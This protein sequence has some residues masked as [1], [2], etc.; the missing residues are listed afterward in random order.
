MNK[1]LYRIIFNKKRGQLMA[2]AEISSSQGKGQ[3]GESGANYLLSDSKLAVWMNAVALAVTCAVGAIGFI[4]SL[5]PRPAFA[6]VVANRNAPANQQA[7]VLQTANGLPQ[8]N[9]QTPNSAGVSVNM[10]SQFDV[11]NNGVILNNSRN[12]VQ[13]QQA[14]WVAANPWLATGTAK[15]ILNEVNSSNPSLLNGYVEVAGDRAG[16]VIA[17][18]SGISVSGGGFI[19]ASAVT[20]TTGV[21]VLNS[22]GAID[23]YRVQSGNISVNGSGLDLSTTD[24]AAILARAIQVNA[25]IWANQLS[26]VAG[27][28]QVDA[29]SLAT[30]T[31]PTTTAISGVG[32]TPSFALDVA[33]IGGMYAGKIFLIGTDAGLGVRN[34]GVIAANSGDLVLSSNGWLSNNGTIQASGNLQTNTQ[35]D[36]TNAG[37]LYATANQ[38]INATGNLSNSGVIAAQGN[39]TL[40]ANSINST[41]GSVWGAGIKSDGTLA[42]GGDLNVTAI[43]ALQANGQNVTAGNMSITAASVDISA[44]KTSGT[45]IAITSGSTL[46]TSQAIVVANQNLNITSGSL[47]NQGGTLVATQN[48]NLQTQA[49]NNDSGLIQSGANLI[50][51]TQGQTLINTNASNFVSSNT[52]LSGKGGITAQGNLTV[53]TGTTDNS[54]GSIVAGKQLQ[55]QAAGLTGAGVISSLADLSVTL[56]SDYTPQGTLQ[57]GGNMSLQTSGNFNNSS[58]IIP[59]GQLSITALNMTNSGELESG[60]NLNVTAGNAITNTGTMVGASVLFNAGKTIQNTGPSALI[61][62]TSQSGQ[63]TLLAPLIVNADPVSVTDSMPTTA[64]YGLGKVNLAGGVDATNSYTLANSIIN[65]SALIQS[66]GDMTINAATLTNTR[67]VLTMSTLFNQPVSQTV[68][69]QLGISL[70]GITGQSDTP[71]PNSIGG[72]Y[73]DPPHGGSMNSD[74]LYTQYI[75][76]ANQNATTAISPQAQIIVGGN[77]SPRVNL[78]QNYWSQIAAAGN[79][80]LTG[81]SVD[82]NSWRGAQAAQIKVSYS[83]TYNYRTYRSTYWTHT[84]C[85]SGCDAPGDDRTYTSNL[86]NS[87]LTS[88]GNITG[89]GV[90]ISNGSPINGVLPSP[91]QSQTSSLSYNVVNSGLFR[92][93]TNPTTH[94]LV[95]SN[96]QFTD[97]QQ[98]LSSDFI[99]KSLG[100]NP[101]TTQVRLGDGFFEQQLITQQIANLTGKQFLNN[102][103]NSQQEYQDLMTNGVAYAKAQNLSVGVELTASQMAGLTSNIVWLVNKN[104]TLADGTVTQ[105]LVPQVY[106]APGNGVELQ[107]NGSLIAAKNVDLTNIVSFNNS[108]TI[109]ATNTLNLQTAGSLNNSNGALNAGGQMTLNA[110]KD[111]DLTGATVQAQNLNMTAGGNTTLATATNTTQ[112]KTDILSSTQ[113]RLGSVANISVSQNAQITAAGDLTINGANLTVGGNLQATAGGNLNIGTVQT[114]DQK[115]LQRYGGVGA[116]D[117]LSQKGSSI[118]VGQ[119]T[120]LTAAQNIN[121]EGGTL[122]LGGTSANQANLSANGS[123]NV[124]DIKNTVQTNS[125]S[126]GSSGGGSYSEKSNNYDETVKSANINSQGALNLMTGQDINLVG[127][128]LASTESIQLNAAGSV[129]V[130]EM[131][132]IH[133]KNQNTSESSGAFGVT[134]T[135]GSAVDTQA[136]SKAVASELSA[137]QNLNIQVGNTALIEGAKLTAIQTNISQTTASIQAGQTAQVVLTASVDTTQASHT[138]QSGTLGVWQ[139]Q[140]GNG[141]VKQTA[142]LTQVKGGLTIGSG[143][144]VTTQ[145][146]TSLTAADF[147]AQVQALS[148]QPG[149]GYLSQLQNNP[150]VNWQQVS[151]TQQSWNYSQQGLTPAGAALLSIAVA[152]ATSGAGSSL[153]GTTTSAGDFTAAS[154]TSLGGTTLGATSATGAISYTATGAALN[155]GFS[156]LAA[157]ASVALAN[158]GG[159]IGK[160]LQQM[161]SAQSV[162]GLVTTMAT[163]GALQNLDKVLGFD[164]TQTVTGQSG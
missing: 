42:A 72:V 142:N 132:E 155:A 137:G 40:T 65:S 28:N 12:N 107:S 9:I 161:G 98:W 93:N 60:S 89:S 160:T 94:Y 105:A 82:Q 78:L 162:K 139:S 121:V 2:M 84:F 19:N 102:E 24:Y 140:A 30:N 20:L 117:A 51:N 50:I 144:Q 90:S 43:Q 48:G 83:G 125:S 131:N 159:D 25:G 68:L 113:T 151:L 23:S 99:L 148:Q 67:R 116:T 154:T 37:S 119:N 63:L 135:K 49:L 110:A 126:S 114:E 79:I 58:Q 56:Q 100:M 134:V 145:T 29:N 88:N 16:V 13:T 33:S 39:T 7:T 61:G 47:N 150:K 35:G 62:A 41:A 44:S 38:T 66:G 3:V 1:N 152:A 71:N 157:Q 141:A 147:Q 92:T 11:L 136:S 129:N 8:I 91:V 5:L 69:N 87:S 15:V 124:T 81:V 85:D 120:S 6:Q 10:Y 149:L 104:V 127:S 73:I 133:Q 18:P 80:D 22:S 77:L 96:P 118:T 45:T 122:Q 4:A 164:G 109:Q 36:V 59:V 57:A 26:V 52:Q 32:A 95:A 76:V 153:I 108:G 158:N 123:I 115:S 111:I 55:I 34:A 21:P 53:T 156:S 146:P 74:Y 70:S 46:N 31:T 163:A 27:A 97:Y 106:L 54:N 103:T 14:G 130:I 75:G 17:N 86:Y 64:I 101:S 138:E 128:K 143:L 112:L